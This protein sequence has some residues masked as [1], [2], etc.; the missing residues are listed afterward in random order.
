VSRG[1]TTLVTTNSAATATA[2]AVKAAVAAI[3]S[4]GLLN[5]AIGMRRP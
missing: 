5:A 1:S 3:R 2:H 4:A